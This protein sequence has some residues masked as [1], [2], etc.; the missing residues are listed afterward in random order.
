[1]YGLD[2][3]LSFRVY[4]G[5]A[6]RFIGNLKFLCNQSKSLNLVKNVLIGNAQIDQKSLDLSDK[7]LLEKNTY[8]TKN[9]RKEKHK[10]TVY[11]HLLLPKSEF[12]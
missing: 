2:A 4:D 7:S 3:R 5:A 9:L 12:T 11:K 10:P 6:V 8:S 1:M